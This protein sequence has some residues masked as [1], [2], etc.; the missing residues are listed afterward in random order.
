M[1]KVHVLA[2]GST[3]VDEALPFSSRSRDPLAFTGLFRGKKHKISVPVRAYLV[4][5]PQGLVLIDTGWD[6]AIR[7][8]ARK[9]EGFANYFASPGEMPEGEGVKDQLA[10]LGYSINDLDAVLMTHLDIDHAGGLQM[11]KD[12]PEIYCSQKE[13]DAAQKSNP[14]YLKRLWNGIDMKTFNDKLDLFDHTITSIAMPGHS[15]GMTAYHIGNREKY[16]LIAG[17]AGYGRRSYE[18]LDLPG[19]E[20][21]KKS[22][23]CSLKRL[24]EIAADPECID[25]LMTH[26]TEEKQNEYEI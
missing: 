10:G 5:L 8:D 11:V 17:D 18:E 21:D 13:W 22:A 7:K 23:L 9:Y 19:V 24:K 6:E 4:E 16:I 26:D 12:V 25:I 14:R 15:A 20:W 3:T 1:I 2:C